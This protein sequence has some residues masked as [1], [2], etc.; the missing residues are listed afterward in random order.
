M[1][2]RH[3]RHFV[4]V[5]EELHFARAASR[6][7]IE[8]SP[9]SQSIRKLELEL[10]IRLLQRTTRRTWLT[11]AGTSFY[12][13][14]IR[15]LQ[16]VDAMASTARK[17]SA[18]QPATIRLALGEDL[19]SQPFARLLDCLERHKPKL[20]V[21]VRELHHADSVRLVREGGADVVISLAPLEEPELEHFQGWSEP[22]VA[23]LPMEHVLA[24]RKRISL[25][26]LSKLTLILPSSTEHPGYLS[27]VAG[28]LERYKIGFSDHRI[29]RHW[30][31]AASFVSTTQSVALCPATMLH[32]NAAIA[33]VPLEEEDA[34]L[35][36]WIFYQRSVLSPAVSLILKLAKT[37]ECNKPLN[38]EALS[39]VSAPKQRL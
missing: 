33:I 13:D 37:I 16:D 32:P 24:S 31:T 3:L 27:Q 5:A 38:E 36:T 10:G 34:V 12:K 19:A 25:C 30:S 28:L 7:G 6:L 26:D 39:T 20:N 2:L 4:A 18:E 1:E 21:E 35:Q 22:I 8:Q 14:A 23:A 17:A 11:S 9:L 15:I 29:V